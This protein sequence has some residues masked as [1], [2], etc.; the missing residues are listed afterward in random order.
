MK[1][2]EVET[3]KEIE[4]WLNE[5]KMQ[6]QDSLVIEGASLEASLVTDDVALKVSLVIEELLNESNSLRDECSRLGNENISYDNKSSS[7]GDNASDAEKKL[8]DTVASDIEYADIGPSYNSDTVSEV[9]HDTFE[10]RY[11][12]MKNLSIFDTFVVNENNSDIIFDIPNMD[13]DRDEN[14]ICTLRDYS[15]PSHKGYRHTIEVPDENNVVPLRSDTIR[16]VQNGCSFHRLRSE[17]P[18]QHLKDFLKLMDSLDLDVANRER[19]RLRL[20]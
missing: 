18:N 3:I 14:P 4:K 9:H 13:P 6:T 2:R 7:L 1:E 11:K 19:T 16:L 17:D 15:K 10:K 5:S 20:F 12:V 8:F